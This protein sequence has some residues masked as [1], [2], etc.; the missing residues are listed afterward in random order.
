MHVAADAV[1]HLHHMR[2]NAAPV[3]VLEDHN[4]PVGG[5]LEEF[6]ERFAR[7]YGF[8][9]SHFRTLDAEERLCDT[10]QDSSP[11]KWESSDKCRR[12]ASVPLVLSTQ[13]ARR[14]ARQFRQ[15]FSM[16]H[17]HSA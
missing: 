11:L 2:T 13:T 3:A 7:F 9:V 5:S 4:G 15:C 16:L 1:D 14:S 12:T 6:V 17:V 10:Q 8:E